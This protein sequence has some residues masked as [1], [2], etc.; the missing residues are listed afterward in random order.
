M[1]IFIKCI[2]CTPIQTMGVS[3]GGGFGG[4]GRTPLLGESQTPLEPPLD[5][6]QRI[7]HSM[8]YIYITANTIVSVCYPPSVKYNIFNAIDIIL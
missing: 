3:G 6:N 8:R 5:E 4:F 1:F 2:Y 7:S